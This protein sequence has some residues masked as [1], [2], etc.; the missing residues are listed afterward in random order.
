MGLVHRYPENQND[1][2]AMEPRPDGRTPPL[3]LQANLALLRLNTAPLR[4]PTGA[5]QLLRAIMADNP[6]PGPH[7]LHS[8]SLLLIVPAFP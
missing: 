5:Q 8:S 1:P 2:L 4:M 6:M 7:R 3:A